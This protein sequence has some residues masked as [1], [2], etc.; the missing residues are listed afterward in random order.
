[1]LPPLAPSGLQTISVVIHTIHIGIVQNSTK[2]YYR[3]PNFLHTYN[4][5]ITLHK[6]I[7]NFRQKKST[8]KTESFCYRIPGCLVKF[9]F[10][11][12]TN[13]SINIFY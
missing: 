5:K 13:Q 9:F 8:C 4:D 3:Y 7:Q 2:K 12:Y 1:M 11:K 6:D 10:F